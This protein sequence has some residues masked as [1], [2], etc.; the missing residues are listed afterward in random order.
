M[1]LTTSTNEK[2]YVSERRPPIPLTV[3]RVARGW[4]Q[5][6][7]AERAGLTKR[8]INRIE[9]RHGRPTLQTAATLATVLRVD[10]E[11]LFP[12]EG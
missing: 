10:I 7:L 12:P 3:W 8:T 9:R 5:Q 2:A 11:S 4:T 6:D 1:A